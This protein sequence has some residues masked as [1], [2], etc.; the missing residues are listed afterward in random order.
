MVLTT[1]G[2]PQPRPMFSQHQDGRQGIIIADR[3]NIPL[4]NASVMY[5]MRTLFTCY[6][7]WDLPYPTQYQLLFEGHS[8]HSCKR[9]SFNQ[10]EK[11]FTNIK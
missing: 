7:A 10:I 8:E 5:G 1:N 4:Q 2:H 11:Q 6:Y 9:N 3:I